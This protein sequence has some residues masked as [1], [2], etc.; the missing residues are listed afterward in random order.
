MS[1]GKKTTLG[2]SAA[3]VAL[4]LSLGATGMASAATTTP[5][6]SASSATAETPANATRGEGMKEGRGG[7]GPRGGGVDAAELASKLGVE[8][9]AVS[10]AL[11]TARDAAMADTGERPDR[12][13]ME[14]SRV[15]SLAEALG[16]DETTVRTAL[17]ELS[18][19]KQVERSAAV[20]E[21]LNTAVA[22][23][24]LTQAEADGAA[25]AVEL[26]ILGGGGR[27]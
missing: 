13:A 8:E 23:G 22:D 16:L 25:K 4:G 10:D 12:E 27:G 20:Q 24:S 17:D 21:R 6:P 15:T 7:H 19:E 2:A 9:S 14:A 26:G 11:Q 3:A 5:T 1:N 18:A